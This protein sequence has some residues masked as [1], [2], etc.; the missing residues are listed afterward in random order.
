MHF[1]LAM[2]PPNPQINSFT[3][4]FLYYQAGAQSCQSPG[5]N[6]NY[7]HTNNSANVSMNKSNSQGTVQQQR[8]IKT[9]KT[10][11]KRGRLVDPSNQVFGTPDYLS[12]E[13]LLGNGYDCNLLIRIF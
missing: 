7:H 13:L 2:T 4:S 9:P 12:P 6:H 8:Y 11:K 10:I 5:M 1:Q 3:S